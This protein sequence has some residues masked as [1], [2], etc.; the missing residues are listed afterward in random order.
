[1]A[2]QDTYNPKG[3]LEIIRIWNNGAEEQLFSDKNTI[4]SGMGVGLSYM[5]AASGQRSIKDFQIGRFQLGTSSHAT[6]GPSTVQ[7]ASA[8][9]INQYGTNPDI[10]VSSLDQIINGSKVTG[11]AFAVIPFNLIRRVD[12]TSVQFGL[13]LGPNTANL[14]TTLKEVGLFMNNPFGYSP[15]P[16]PILVAYKTFSPVEK[17]DQFSLLFKWTITF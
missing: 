4:V 6:Y 10:T 15:T 5:F 7:L 17:T 3:Y 2:N 9:S 11:N 8:L 14:S 13:F 12:K 1:M 16:A